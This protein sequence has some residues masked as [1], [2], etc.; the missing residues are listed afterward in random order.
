M[1]QY[2]AAA[3]GGFMGTIIA[4]LG[5]RALAA[6]RR[7]F[8]KETRVTDW[9]PWTIVGKDGASRLV[10]RE[11]RTK[12][13]RAQ[14]EKILDA[15]LARMGAAREGRPIPPMVCD[16]CGRL[17]LNSAERWISE[18]PHVANGVGPCAA[19]GLYEEPAC[20]FVLTPAFV[21]D[22]VFCRNDG[23]GLT[24]AESESWT[25]CGGESG[26]RHWW[27]NPERERDSRAAS[28]IRPEDDK[29]EAIWE[30]K[31]VWD[32]IENGSL[33]DAARLILTM[34]GNGDKEVPC[35][36]CRDEPVRADSRAALCVAC[37][38]EESKE[39][40]NG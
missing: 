8:R 39:V 5:G 18:W 21:A 13:Q 15:H 4:L 22:K 29:Y 6:A 26:K 28:A 2:I 33:L 14:S 30:S 3:L 34:A 38:G 17:A 1:T 9:V 16:N 12:E 36:C 37:G 23:C 31:E 40:Q 11:A 25:G 20:A 27:T 10:H 24:L 35:A 19:P 32:K 7:R